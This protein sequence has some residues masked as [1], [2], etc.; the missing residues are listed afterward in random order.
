MVKRQEELSE[1]EKLMQSF[2][3][4]S[5]SIKTNGVVEDGAPNNVE[6][7]LSLVDF[8]KN[9]LPDESLSDREREI[10]ELRQFSS[11]FAVTKPALEDGPE[12]RRD[13]EDEGAPGDAFEKES[14]AMYAS[15]EGGGAVDK[16]GREDAAADI[17]EQTDKDIDSKN[18]HDVW[19]P[20]PLSKYNNANHFAQGRDQTNRA[21]NYSLTHDAQGN[22]LSE[23]E[24]AAAAAD[25]LTA[26]TAALES[27]MA[28]H[29]PVMGS[30]SK[31][32]KT[33]PGKGSALKSPKKTSS[34]STRGSFYSIG[35]LTVTLVSCVD[36]PNTDAGNLCLLPRIDL[37]SF[38][39]TKASTQF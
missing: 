26:L 14:K 3:I 25:S 31:G 16:L 39:H 27:N 21:L 33:K 22:P 30:P 9:N 36:L 34:R 4:F 17:E 23:A 12:D 32:K 28:G 24:A 6:D 11:G 29:G 2:K 1:R 19:S 13:T 35:I 5:S 10:Q 7:E 20:D 15:E 8:V 38:T 37:L 18:A